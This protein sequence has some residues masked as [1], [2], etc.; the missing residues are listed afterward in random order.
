MM[1]LLISFIGFFIPVQMVPGRMALLVTIF[2]MLVNITTSLKATGPRVSN[3]IYI[4]REDYF[5]YTALNPSFQTDIMTAQDSWM[6]LAMITLC[7][8]LF[9]YA[10]LLRIRFSNAA[11]DYRWKRGWS[12]KQSNSISSM[13]ARC[14]PGSKLPTE[15]EAHCESEE[16][17]IVAKC[18]TIDWWAFW[19]FLL[20]SVFVNFVYFTYFM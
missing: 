15:T 10:L 12:A 18:R 5:Y 4:L 3:Q 11:P 19:G 7:L 13:K 20:G 1:L 8:E 14:P 9:E 16:T 17:V 2:L 6:L